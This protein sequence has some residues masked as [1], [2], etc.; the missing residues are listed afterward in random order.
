MVILLVTAQCKTNRK[1]LLAD[2]DIDPG[3]LNLED[4]LPF[5]LNAS[6]DI[7]FKIDLRNVFDESLRVGQNPISQ[8]LLTAR[9][10]FMIF[11]VPWFCSQRLAGAYELDAKTL[12]ARKIVLG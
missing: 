8:H 12:Q 4:C 2:V 11:V 6:L 1:Q 10:T 5:F 9:G 7:S 3:A